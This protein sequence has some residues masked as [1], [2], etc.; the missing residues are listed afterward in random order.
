[1]ESESLIRPCDNS[2]FETIWAVINDGAQAYCGCIPPDRLRNPYM[3][4]EELRAEIADGVRFWAWE[5]SGGVAGVMGLQPVED[6]TLIR[7]AYVRT[8]RQHEGIGSRMLRHLRTMVHGPIL[9]G[10]WADATCDPFL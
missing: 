9:I 6:V 3:S 7:H 1:M 5:D 10:T 8:A 2:D 4:R